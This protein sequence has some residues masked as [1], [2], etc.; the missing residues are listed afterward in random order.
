MILSFSVENYRSLRQTQHLTLQASSGKNHSGNW[1]EVPAKPDSLRLLQAAVLYG[2]NASGKSNVLKAFHSLVWL[3]RHSVELSVGK[4]IDCYEPYRLDTQS[5]AAPTQF[6]LE[7]VT[8]GIRYEYA[9][10]FDQFTIQKERL[11]HYPEGRPALVFERLTADADFD[12]VKLGGKIRKAHTA[13]QLF[14]NQLFLS[15]F[16]KVEPHPQLTPIYQYL[17]QIQIWNAN[18][19]IRL[20]SWKHQFLYELVDED[21]KGDLLRRL[22]SLVANLDTGISSIHIKGAEEDDFQFPGFVPDLVRE[23]MIQ[24]YNMQVLTMHP[25]YEGD[26]VVGEVAFKLEEESRGTQ[27]LFGLAG[28][29]LKV[30]DQGGV[31]MF[32]EL[33]NSLHP[34]LV[35]FLVQLFLHPASNPHHAQLIFATHEISLLEKGLL[36]R[37]QIWFTQK[38]RKGETELYSAYDFEGIRDDSAFDRL[39]RN[40]K[41]RALPKVKASE[42]LYESPEA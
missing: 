6:S 27:I 21:P 39:Y 15:Q 24:Q 17:D 31:L 35:R 23:R 26:G 42:Y 1:V 9:I 4:P 16:G 20:K 29:I 41:F 2:P 8:E 19:E 3:V 40:G 37:D 28:L 11:I 5:Q 14:K 30:L 18:D 33:E 34:D 32:D 25:V 10:A 13:R 12:Q 7:F 38:N 22:E 36:R